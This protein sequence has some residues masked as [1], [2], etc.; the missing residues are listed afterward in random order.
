MIR[1]KIITVP[2]G[3]VTKKRYAQILTVACGYVIFDDDYPEIEKFSFEEIPPLSSVNL[4]ITT[5]EARAPFWVG[6]VA[7][8]KLG[9]E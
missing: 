8:F 3:Q 7:G 9:K 4:F 5:V 6:F 2:L 1:Q